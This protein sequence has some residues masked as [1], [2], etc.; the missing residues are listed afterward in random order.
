MRMVEPVLDPAGADP[1]HQPSCDGSAGG[2]SDRP[3]ATTGTTGAD[4]WKLA[5]IARTGGA[6][7]SAGGVA[8][9]SV[10]DVAVDSLDGA[11]VVATAVVDI[12]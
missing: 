11:G 5:R 7:G 4:T 12:G 3:S 2:I 6:A 8:T 10:A 9:D 1:I